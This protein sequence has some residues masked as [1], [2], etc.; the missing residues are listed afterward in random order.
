M[1]YGKGNCCVVLHSAGELICPSHP[2]INDFIDARFLHNHPY[3]CL[4]ANR[5]TRKLQ[6]GRRC[7]THLSKEVTFDDSSNLNLSKSACEVCSPHPAVSLY[8]GAR[9]DFSIFQRWASLAHIACKPMQGATT[10]VL[11]V[12]TYRQT[13]STF[14]LAILHGLGHPLYLLNQRMCACDHGLATGQIPKRQRQQR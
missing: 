7:N 6:R 10:A 9:Q 12:S 13:R 4:G 8:F 1:R 14:N 5:H 3:Y 2:H 11:Y